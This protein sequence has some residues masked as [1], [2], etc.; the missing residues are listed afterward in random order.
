MSLPRESVAI[1]RHDLA[2]GRG[3]AAPLMGRALAANDC[4]G[5]AEASFGKRAKQA[6]LAAEGK[7]RPLHG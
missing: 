1:A 7:R 2:A 6:L 4:V 5:G 3:P